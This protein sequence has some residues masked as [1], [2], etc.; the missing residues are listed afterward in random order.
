MLIGH[1]AVAF[2]AKRFLPQYSLGLLLFAATFLDILLAFTFLLLGGRPGGEGVAGAYPPPARIH[3][4]SHAF[5]T[6]AVCSAVWAAVLWLWSKN[7]KPALTFGLIVFSHWLLDL[8]VY[9]SNLRLYLNGSPR[10][11]L[12]G[13]YS[14]G[15]GLILEGLT[16]AAGLWLYLSSTKARDRTGQYGCFAYAALLVGGYLAVIFRVLPPEEQLLAGVSVSLLL[17]PMWAAWF[18]EHRSFNEPMG[19]GW[20]EAAGGLLSAVATRLP[21]RAAQHPT[22]ATRKKSSLRGASSSPRLARRDAIDPAIRWDK[23]RDDEPVARDSDGAAALSPRAWPRGVVLQLSLLILLPLLAAILTHAIVR[24]ILQG[25]WSGGNE[26]TLARASALQA[27]EDF[28]AA[29]RVAGEPD[30]VEKVIDGQPALFRSALRRYRM[31]SDDIAWIL[32]E[33]LEGKMKVGGALA[34][35][36]TNWQFNRDRWV[37][38]T[39]EELGFERITDKQSLVNCVL[40]RDVSITA[41]RLTGGGGRPYKVYIEVKSLMNNRESVTCTVPKGQIFELNG[42][43]ISAHLSVAHGERGKKLT[44]IYVNPEDFELEIPPSGKYREEIAYCGNAGL[45][46]SNG[47][48]NLTVFKIADPDFDSQKELHMNLD[49]LNR[50]QLS[51]D[52]SSER[53]ERAAGGSDSEVA[54]NVPQR[55]RTVR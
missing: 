34:V 17:L 31:S 51:L 37:F 47:D 45:A 12:G 52:V 24:R 13:W 8:F 28:D 2:A 33:G 18:D 36:T 21:R 20:R 27:K 55:R 30:P 1:Q 54:S 49:A 32:G 14:E 48:G 43:S 53:A 3:L 4:A 5:L 10:V 15:F 16:L 44:Q 7:W 9:P 26:A 25:T 29:F 22:R 39:P 50:R 42:M 35:A 38:R 41:L 46:P 11:A 19:A 6:A 40:R 23:R